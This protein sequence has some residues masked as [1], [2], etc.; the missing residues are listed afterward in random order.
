MPKH[1]TDVRSAET[2]TARALRAVLA[3][4]P[5]IKIESISAES[6]EAVWNP[7]LI[8]RLKVHGRPHLLVCGFKASGQP[9]FAR[10]M[11][12]ELRDDI[13]HRATRA[14][15]VLIAPYLSPA[16]R[17]MCIDAGV[18]YLDLNGNVR[19]SFG[20]IFIERVTAEKPAA[21]RRALKSLFSPKSAQV[22]RSML[23]Q[24][25]R[26]WRVSELAEHSRVSLGHVSNVRSAL[27][28]REWALAARSSGL[29]LSNPDAI[30]DAWREVYVVPPGTHA[31]FYTPL[32]GS[33]FLAAAKKAF[34]R[35]T[36]SRR[37][38]FSSFSAAHWLAPFARSGMHHFLA[39]DEGLVALQ[40]T[41]GLTRVTKG[42]NVVITVPKDLGLL[43][44]VVEPAPGVVC[45]G[46]IQTYL[47]LSVAG[48]RGLEAADFLRR[49]LLS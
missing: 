43:A 44:D 33:A 45:T 40:E 21:H 20:G 34:S 13:R 22:L 12:L 23:V 35:N 14:T 3:C 37:V 5:M 11:L 46:P 9:R 19:L 8:A 28:D 27:L 10:A 2:P 42:E 49:A 31:R 36:D 1:A 29:A 15:P 38:A 32:H 18:S 26:T 39:D 16:V 41:L 48:E 30:L 24:P 4:V 7:D 6:G 17:Q 47:D 25:T